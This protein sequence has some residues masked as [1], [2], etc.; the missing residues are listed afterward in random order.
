MGKEFYCVG[1]DWGDD[2]YFRSYEKAKEFMWN[3][4]TEHF[5]NE[6]EKEH[7]DAMTELQTIRS[8]QGIGVIYTYEFE[9]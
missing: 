4:Y 3:Y 7:E 9:D 6:S 5:D 1:F 8:I 2:F